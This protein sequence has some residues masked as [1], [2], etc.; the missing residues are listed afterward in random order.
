MSETD[1]VLDLAVRLARAAGAL[2]RERY[3]TRLEIRAKTTPINLVT[4]VDHA[5]E[6]LVVEGIAAERPQD[7]ILAEEGSGRDRE[8]ARWRW[9]IDP[10][11]GTTNYAH[12]YP[13]F[14]V[15]I[16][17]ECKGEPALGVVYDPLLDELYHALAGGGAFRNGRAIHVSGEA[18]LGRSLLATGF[19]YDKAVNDDDN[20]AEFRAALK[21]AREV[22]RDG[23]AALDLC[24][25]ASGRFEG[26]WEFQLKAWDVAA[27]A[28]IV[29]EAGGRVSDARGGGDFRSGR[30]IVATNGLIHD[31]LLDLLARARR[32]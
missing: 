29:A 11:D 23:S 28:L 5:C 8:D 7:A 2:Q 3:E 14:A 27:G 25:V 32:G 18:A 24:Y 21:T 6:K 13:R 12:G 9:V 10:L 22:R 31:A 30:Q 15:S 1:A 16:G 19:A 4:E 20:V 26:Y 17:I